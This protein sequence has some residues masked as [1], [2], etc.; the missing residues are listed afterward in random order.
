MINNILVTKCSLLKIVYIL[1]SK[2]NNCRKK[3]KLV[4]YRKRRKE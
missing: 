1:K 4:V 2:N 3:E